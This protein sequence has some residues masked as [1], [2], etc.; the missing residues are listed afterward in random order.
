MLIAVA[1]FL[2]VDARFSPAGLPRVAVV[3]GLHAALGI[4]ILILSTTRGGTAH[5]DRLA[6]GLVLGAILNTFVYLALWPRNPMLIATSLICVLLGPVF[7]FSWSART[8]VALG[9]FT[10]AGFALVGGI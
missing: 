8:M 4:A 7:F 1:V 3:Y 6:L 10:C 5:A 2:P 9:L